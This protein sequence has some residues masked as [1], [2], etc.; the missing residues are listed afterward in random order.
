MPAAAATCLQELEVL[1]HLRA[2]AVR[3]AHV[4]QRVLSHDAL[5]P[6]RACGACLT[7]E[8]AMHTTQAAQEHL[9]KHTF[10]CLAR[11]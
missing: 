1:L 9:G 2:L 5:L 7:F 3:Q 11:R 8:A 4:A 10:H 6:A